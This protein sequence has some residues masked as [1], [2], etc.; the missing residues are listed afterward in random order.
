L[1]EVATHLEALECR[2][3]VRRLLATSLHD[4]VSLFKDLLEE[5]RGT[6]GV[7]RAQR[8]GGGVKGG[9]P[10]RYRSWRNVPCSSVLAVAGVHGEASAYLI[11][12]ERSKVAHQGKVRNAVGDLWR[13]LREHPATRKEL[14]TLETKLF[15]R[16]PPLKEGQTAER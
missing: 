1:R 10:R 16:Y 14:E 12:Y 2:Y 7:L 8:D 3:C 11:H 15:R 9:M 13:E 4:Y 6:E 5:V